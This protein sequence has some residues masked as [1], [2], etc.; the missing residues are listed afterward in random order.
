MEDGK[1][2]GERE[3]RGR[4]RG[5]GER[6]GGGKDEEEGL[7]KGVMVKVRIMGNADKV[8]GRWEGSQSV[9]GMKYI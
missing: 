6:E 8:W 5:G 3:G 4:L 7:G 1:E 2:G 9:R